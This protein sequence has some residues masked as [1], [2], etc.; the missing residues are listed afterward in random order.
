M[1]AQSRSPVVAEVFVVEW[2]GLSILD[3]RKMNGLTVLLTFWT[4]IF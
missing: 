2:R 1:R 4:V 3:N